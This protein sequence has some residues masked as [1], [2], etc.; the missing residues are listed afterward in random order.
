MP[1][2][3]VTSP[4]GRRVKVTHPEGATQGQILSYA[5]QM[6]GEVAP[7]YNPDRHRVPTKEEQREK[8]A[9]N[10]EVGG[11]QIPRPIA[12]GAAGLVSRAKEIGTLGMGGDQQVSDVLRGSP[13]AMAGGALPDVAAMLAG[14]KTLQTA[15]ELTTALPRISGAL[16]A[17]GRGMAGAPKNILEASLPTAT[18]GAGTTED[19][20]SG[21]LGGGIGGALGYG[22]TKGV[23]GALSPNIEQSVRDLTDK[24]VR[25]TTGRI[26]GGTAKRVEDAATSIPLVGDA[27][28]NANT[29]AMQDFN[30]ATI[31]DALGIVGQ[32]LDSATPVGRDAVEEAS[33]KI[34]SRYDDILEK[35][36]VKMDDTAQQEIQK[37]FGMVDSF[38]KSY[39]D[40]TIRQL[41]GPIASKF[42]NPTQTVLGQDF[43]TLMRQLRETYKNAMQLNKPAFEQEAGKAI[44]EVYLSLERA[45]ARQNPDLASALKATDRAY[46]ALS[47]IREASTA[48]GAKDGVFTPAMY[49]RAIKNNAEGNTFSEGRAFGQQFADSAVDVLPQSVPDSGT[50]MRSLVGLGVGGGLHMLAP[51]ATPALLAA[52]ALGASYTQPGQAAI[53][54]M[55]LNRPESARQA[56]LIYENILSPYARAGAAAGGVQLSQ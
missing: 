54:A 11:I 7:A 18:Y 17:A 37:I 27:I 43:K 51:S 56:R 20:I 9:E 38:D 50:A 26:L 22:I 29:R 53:R 23:A 6:L 39:K 45:A 55:L 47:R 19:R 30:R 32:Q 4:D 15:G 8:I 10:F 31:N 25:V 40:W 33:R 36:N 16:S 14:G 52:G 46:A 41:K 34:G 1:T 24:G 49:L 28:K 21:A 44:R 42:D 48:A 13:A 35:M 5:R 12:E 2:T 3:F